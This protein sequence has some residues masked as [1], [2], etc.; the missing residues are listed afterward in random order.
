MKLIGAFFRLIRW[1]NLLFIL[2]TQALFYF[3]I[4]HTLVDSNAHSFYFSG[5]R[6]HLFVLL[7]LASVLIAAAGYIINDYFDLKIDVINKPE[8]VVVDKILK[9]RWAILWHL[10]FSLAGMALSFYISI[11]TGKYIIGVGN[12]VCVMLLWVYSTTFK[13]RVLW[14]NLMIAALTAWVILVIYFYSGAKLLHIEGWKN[15]NYPF[16]IRKLFFF[17]LLY[18]SFAFILTLIREVIKDME[19]L[20]GDA[21][22]N[23]NT[24]PIAW[25]M[26]AA[27]VFVAVWMMV[28]IATVAAAIFYAIQSAWYVVAGYVLA[29]VFIPLLQL[30]RKLRKAE[31]STDYHRMSSMVKWIMLGGIISML[32][33]KT[34][35]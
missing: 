32:F 34:I 4:F 30:Y 3:A 18:S 25:G 27:R 23:C 8:R 33:F 7:M 21:Q 2:L 20:P 35:F 12:T 22:N 15:A 14:G 10:L 19:D 13:R 17:T 31:T 29:V 16:D 11:R 1:Q 24:M 28:L 26:Q 5:E 9:R 6:L